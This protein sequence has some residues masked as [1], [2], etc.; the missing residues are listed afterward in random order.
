VDLLADSAVATKDCG[1]LTFKPTGL[2]P[3]TLRG[4][5]ICE[6]WRPAYRAAAIQSIEAGQ[7]PGA[8]LVARQRNIGSGESSPE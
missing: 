5:R 3:E 4:R 7:D 6:R 1:K 2:P 8:K